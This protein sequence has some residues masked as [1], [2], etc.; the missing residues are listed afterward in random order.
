MRTIGEIMVLAANYA[1]EGWMACD[2]ASLNANDYK[3]LYS[4]IG[5]TYGGN[6]ENFN[7]PKKADLDGSKYY[8]CVSNGSY[9]EGMS[10]ILSQIKLFA[11]PQDIRGWVKCQGQLLQI[12]QNTQLFSVLGTKWGGDG[13][14]TFGVPNIPS[15]EGGNYW[16]DNTNTIGFD[17]YENSYPFISEIAAFGADY[18]LKGWLS[19]NGELVPIQNYESLFALIENRYSPVGTNFNIPKL[20]PI[21]KCGYQINYNGTFPK[22]S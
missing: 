8:I 9:P 7:L 22:R 15:P 13:R 12:A 3:E 18:T 10:G 11:G 16:I 4:I 14:T 1:P 2:G 21:D 17:A 5:T 6:S 19:C 20:A